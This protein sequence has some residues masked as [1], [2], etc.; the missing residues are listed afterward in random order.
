MPIGRA[1]LDRGRACAL[2][3]LLLCP[4]PVAAADLLG[5][6]RGDC[7][8]DQSWDLADPIGLLV[9]LL[10]NGPL[11][12]CAD[13]CDANDDG[14]LDI[15]DGIYSLSALFVEGPSPGAPYPLCG[16]DPTPDNLICEDPG[17]PIGPLASRRQWIGPTTRVGLELTAALPRHP[18]SP[19]THEAS[20]APIVPDTPFVEYGVRADAL[21]PATLTLDTVTGDLS[22]T[23]EVGTKTLSLWGRD[24]VGLFHEIDAE[25]TA[26][27][28]NESERIPG[29][30]FFDPGPH[31][32]SIV[33]E[34]FLYTHDLPWPYPYELWNC[35]G[36]APPSDSLTQAKLLRIH[37]PQVTVG[38]LPLLIFHHGS[39]FTHSDYDLLLGRIA[40]HGFIVASV[41]DATSFSTLPTYYCWGGHDEAARVLVA[42]RAALEGF[43]G[44]VGHPLFQRIDGDRVFYGGHSRGGASAIVAAEFDPRT[45]GVIAL[46]PTDAKADSTIAGTDRW[47]ELPDLPIL[48]IAAEQDTDVVYPWAE[49][50]TERTTGAAT[51]VTIY[52]G[53]HGFTTDASLNGCFN[54][55]W[56]A[57]APTV[58]QCPYIS[59]ETQQAISTHLAVVFLR[60]W[61]LDDLSVEG[62]LDG[63]EWLGSP[64]ASVSSSR[65]FS[66]Q[67]EVDDFAEFP[68]LPSGEIWSV[69]GVAVAELG[70]CYDSPIPLPTPIPAIENLILQWNGALG[71]TRLEA[72]LDPAVDLAD[73]RVFRFR[74]KNH[75]RWQL[76]D[77]FG[78][79]WL[80]LNVELDDT[81]GTTASVS[82]NAQLAGEAV[83][84]DSTPAS[85]LLKR[86]RFIDVI[87]PLDE[88]LIAEPTLDLSEIAEVRLRFTIDPTATLQTV[89]R[90]GLD[91]LRFE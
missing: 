31:P 78:L 36:T 66:P 82:L 22:G 75:D 12:P 37:V 65:H 40:S 51:M 87:A 1:L 4:A 42:T 54:C 86:Q 28:S 45:R 76:L 60:R 84:P 41:N 38:E 33:S 39:G 88:F 83:H 44:E 29:Q 23:L 52:G 79:G 27:S 85:V 81:L 10:A 71:E 53:C 77:N 30:S 48:A 50:L 62:W 26:F 68:T 49:R 89:P 46:Q 63:E 32:V 74:L 80:Q 5:F 15:S 91:D 11:P 67:I 18:Q 59:R 14:T 55:N 58:D 19:V 64:L 8:A 3:L 9:W 2:A 61:G 16:F 17:C 47:N 57:N 25:L 56:E 6:Q 20:G 90:I 73:A 72:P 70:S 24:S 35:L 69:T 43:S 34:S 21:L 13:A 7:N